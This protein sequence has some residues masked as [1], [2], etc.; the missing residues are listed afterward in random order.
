ADAS[1]LPLASGTVTVPAGSTT[2]T[3]PVSVTDDNI[4]EDDEAFTVVLTDASHGIRLARSQATG[5]ITDD[6]DPPSLRIEAARVAEGHTALTDAQMNV[7]LSGP[8]AKPIT[9]AYA[10]SDGTATAPGDYGTATGTLVI[11]AGQNTATVH[12]PVHGNTAVEPDESLA[13]SLSAPDNATLANASAELTIVD[14]DAV[15]VQVTSPVVTEGT[16]ATT[17][18]T[19]EV[20]L[21][22]PAPAGTQV[23]VPYRLEGLTATVP[24]DVAPAS[25]TLSFGPGDGA[26]QVTVN[27]VGD[28]VDE[29]DE[30]FRLVLG[31]PQVTGTRPV[32]VGDNAAAVIVDDDAETVTNLPPTCD[33][34]AATIASLWPANHKL[35]AV[36]VTGGADPD[37]DAVTLA[38][39][40]VTQDEA[41]NGLGDGDVSPD[42]RPGPAP[43]QVQLRAERS[44]TGDGRVYRLA[45]TATDPNGADCSTVVTVAVPRDQRRPAVDSGAQFNS[46]G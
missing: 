12:V 38:V 19:F 25:G 31:V 44:G 4:D 1:D 10:T 41:V 22:P 36:T 32:L 23:S 15:V 46:F 43:N 29:P 33:T 45:V 30:S 8:S 39:G 3:I 18:A 14:D 9:V 37:G 7:V 28:D 35:V 5:T 21:N 27:V 16:G 34:V 42:A 26:Q 6:D 2:A 13:V 24:D 40:G 20:A 17:A 11:P